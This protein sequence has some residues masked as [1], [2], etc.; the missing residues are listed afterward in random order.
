MTFGNLG[1]AELSGW[2]KIQSDPQ[3]KV[4]DGDNFE[5]SEIVQLKFSLEVA[6]SSMSR[7]ENVN[8]GYRYRPKLKKK[9]PLTTNRLEFYPLCRSL[10]VRD[11]ATRQSNKFATVR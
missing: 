3:C 4:K 10:V 1:L 9:I 2:R 5:I 6:A 8:Y 11:S 7:Q